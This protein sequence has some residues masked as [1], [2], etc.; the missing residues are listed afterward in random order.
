M[1]VSQG[2]NE[3]SYYIK[4]EQ[5]GG[6]KAW[7]KTSTSKIDPKSGERQTL[8]Q[9][10]Y[11]EPEAML[12]SQKGLLKSQKRLLPGQSSYHFDIG[13]KTIDVAAAQTLP[14]QESQ[15]L[16]LYKSAALRVFMRVAV[17]SEMDEPLMWSQSLHLE[18][19]EDAQHEPSEMIFKVLIPSRVSGQFYIQKQSRFFNKKCR[20]FD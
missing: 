15:P 4:I 8:L 1:R 5:D 7:V 17:A 10:I 11:E 19:S 2:K 16:L 20:F 6:D 9:E 12:R 3:G 14:P 13:D 18:E